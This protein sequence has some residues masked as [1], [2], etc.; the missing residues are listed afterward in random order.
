M[1]FVGLAVATCKSNGKHL[2]ELVQIEA[3]LGVL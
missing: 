1:V 3:M 2:T